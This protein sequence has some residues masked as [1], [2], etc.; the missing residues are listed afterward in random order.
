MHEILQTIYRRKAQNMHDLTVLPVTVFSQV[1]CLL[2]P[3]E[4]RR[5]A[6]SVKTLAGVLRVKKKLFCCMQHL[7][8]L[9]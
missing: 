3:P 6:Q 5:P 8:L 7:T 1:K 4:Y 2:L 9:W